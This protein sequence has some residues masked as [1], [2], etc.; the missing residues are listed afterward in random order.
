M[1]GHQPAKPQGDGC[2]LNGKFRPT[3]AARTL[4]TKARATARALSVD[5]MVEALFSRA[6]RRTEFK[7]ALEYAYLETR[8]NPQNLHDVHGDKVEND[9]LSNC[10]IMRGLRCQTMD[11]AARLFVARTTFKTSSNRLPTTG[12]IQARLPWPLNSR[13][14][15]RAAEGTKDM[16]FGLEIHDCNGRT[17]EM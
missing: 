10:L 11:W 16:V 12:T 13:N 9:P 7:K 5:H 14:R 4:S 6:I 8:I 15:K 3:L 2:E 1:P 17:R